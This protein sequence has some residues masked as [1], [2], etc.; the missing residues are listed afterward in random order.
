MDSRERMAVRKAMDHLKPYL[1]LW[2]DDAFKR[3]HK[4]QGITGARGS[5]IQALAKLVLDQWNPIFAKMLK[6]HARTYF[7]EL[8]DLRNRWAHE[9]G[10]TPDEVARAN[11]TINQ[12][13]KV[14]GAPQTLQAVASSPRPSTN[15]RKPNQRDTMRLI[16]KRVGNDEDKLIAGYAAAE[17]R[18]DVV[19]KRNKHGMTAEDYARALLK[20]A[21]AKGWLDN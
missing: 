4:A 12:I 5:D 13:L 17:K 15:P 9:D 14:I 18:G 6:P 8:K 2:I 20:D 1:Q 19:R 7:F 11:D 16:F 21:A 3:F 10:F